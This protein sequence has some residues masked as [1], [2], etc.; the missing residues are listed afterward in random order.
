VNRKEKV[1]GDLI[2]T[3]VTKSNGRHCMA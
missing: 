3:F 2:W 1:K